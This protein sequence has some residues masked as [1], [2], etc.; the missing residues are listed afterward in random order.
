MGKPA[1][2]FMDGNLKWL[3]SYDE[4]FAV[5]ATVNNSGVI[6]APFTGRY[7]LTSFSV[8]KQEEVTL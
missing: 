6:T 3:G 4:C 8:G 5:E 2:G 7:C 1:S